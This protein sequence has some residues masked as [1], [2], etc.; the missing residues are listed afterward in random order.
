M[1]WYLYL[2]LNGQNGRIAKAIKLCGPPLTPSLNSNV[3][4]CLGRMWDRVPAKLD[5]RTKSS[6][7]QSA[8]ED[9]R[10]EYAEKDILLVDEIAQSVA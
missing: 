10:D 7:A 9:N 8:E 2:L 1:Q 3:H 4:L 5:V 6:K